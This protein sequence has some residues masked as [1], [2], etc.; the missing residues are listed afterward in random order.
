MDKE[1]AKELS[2]DIDFVSLYF[3]NR[4]KLYKRVVGVTGDFFA[5]K[6]KN[7]LIKWNFYHDDMTVFPNAD[8]GDRVNFEEIIYYEFK[9]K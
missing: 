7:Y 4:K 3:G 9:C 6:N 5:I 1:T 8:Y 2:A